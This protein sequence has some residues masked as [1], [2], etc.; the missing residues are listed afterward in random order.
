MTTGI[1]I[2]QCI[3]ILTFFM[4][5]LAGG[6]GSFQRLRMAA[7]RG[8]EGQH[9]VK[10]RDLRES[11]LSCVRLFVVR[12]DGSFLMLGLG[13]WS[14]VNALGFGLRLEAQGVFLRSG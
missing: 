3:R 5:T 12:G 13:L 11:H 4:S 14:K 9:E 7:D 6:S 8:E 2:V 10:E 1:T